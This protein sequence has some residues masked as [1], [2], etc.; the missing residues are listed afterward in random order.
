MNSKTLFSIVALAG[1]AITVHAQNLVQNPGFETGD[2]PPWVLSGDTSFTS[3]SSANPHTG[4]YTAQL[5]PSS[6]DGFL[7][8]T[9][10]TTIGQNYTVDFWLS[11]G[12][13]GTN[14][15]SASFGGVTVLSLTNASAFGYTEYTMNVAATS[16]SSDMHFAFYNCLLYTS[17]AADDLLC[18]DLGGR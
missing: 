5:G 4:I 8:Q 7:D 12:F 13:S 14:D 15:F 10:P 2:F 11:N 9:I 17:D 18:V 16:S 1:M 6:S 3:V